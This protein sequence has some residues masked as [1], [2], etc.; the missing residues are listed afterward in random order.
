MKRKIAESLGELGEKSVAGE[1]VAMLKDK[2]L[3]DES[4]S[5]IAASLGEL[6]T[7]VEQLRE[8]ASVDFSKGLYAAAY[9]SLKEAAQNMRVRLY[10]DDTVDPPR[11]YTAPLPD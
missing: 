10:R 8:F 7:D 1:L 9:S 5:R 11:F 2:Q 3:A 4:K 6:I